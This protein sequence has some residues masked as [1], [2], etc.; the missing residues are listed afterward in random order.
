MVDITIA[1]FFGGCGILDAVCN[2]INK[3]AASFYSQI[4]DAVP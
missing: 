3:L 2:L 1:D 4:V